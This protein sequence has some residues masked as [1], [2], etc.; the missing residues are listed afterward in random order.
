MA[1]LVDM[2]VKVALFFPVSL[3]R[4]DRSG[5]AELCHL[6]NLIGVVGFIGDEIFSSDA[7]YEEPSLRAVRSGTV[8]NNNSDRHTM[9]IHGQ[10]YLCVE[11]PFERLIA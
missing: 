5:C 7:L 9:R 1:L 2:A 10:M 6:D 3:R 8:C 11:P 4:D